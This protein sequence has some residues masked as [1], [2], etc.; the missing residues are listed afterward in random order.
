[1]LAQVAWPASDRPAAF[2]CGPTAFVET[3]AGLLVA[4][5]YPDT[6]VKTERFGGA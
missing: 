1:M 5:G 4:S 3:V 6:T 2:I